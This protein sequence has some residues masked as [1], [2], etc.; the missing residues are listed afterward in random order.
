MS[1]S[2]RLI[3]VTGLDLVPQCGVGII[4]DLHGD[5]SKASRMQILQCDSAHTGVDKTW[6]EDEA[7]INVG[8]VGLGFMGMI[9]Y[10]TYDRLR[11]V[12][13]R[14][15]CEQ[16]PHRLRGDWRD[17]KGNFGPAGR[18]VDLTRVATFAD[19]EPLLADPTIDL[20]DICLPPALHADVA[21]L[22]LRAGKH[23]LCEKP[24]AIHHAR[25]ARGWRSRRREQERLLMI[26]H[27]LPMFPEYRF[28]HRAVHEGYVW[29]TVGRALST[30]DQRP[31]VAARLL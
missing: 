8:I 7:M 19:M 20:V 18:Q 17:I 2:R 13:V 16:L 23:V 29:S 4:D 12:R 31:G 28:L 3:R 26:G 25:R 5:F 10:Y 15:I 6:M 24:M 9:H 11:G 21:I 1:R 30:S 14:A 27:V 22:A